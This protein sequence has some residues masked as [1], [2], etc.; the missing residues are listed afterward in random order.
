MKKLSAILILLISVSPVFAQQGKTGYT[1]FSFITPAEISVGKDNNFLVDR[2]PA[3]EKLLILSLPA[4]VLVAAPDIRPLGLDDTVY[5]LKPPTIAFQSDSQR[6]EFSFAYQPEIEI[7]QHNSDQNTWNNNASID[8]SRLL[9]RRWQFYAGDMYRSSKDPSRT[10]QNPLLLLP[11]SRYQENDFRTSVGFG[12]SERTWYTLRFDHTLTTF[13]ENDPLQRRLLD[14]IS[15]SG[16]FVFTRM[17]SRN[18]RLRVSYSIFSLQPWNRQKTAD[19][20]V[21]TQFVAFKKPSHSLTAEYRFTLNPSTVFEFTGGAV[22][23]ST[24]TNYVFGAF[25]D[26]RIGE[27]W[28]GGGYSRTLSLYSP[29][30]PGFAT[31]LNANSFYDIINGHLRGQPTRKTG[32]ELSISVSRSAYGTLIN[33]NKTL[34]GRSRVDYRLNDRTV[35]FATAEVYGQNR[36]DF[37]TTPLTRT[38]LFMGFDYSLS[39]DAQRRTSRLNRDAD[40]VALTEHARMRTK[41]P[42]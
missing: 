33:E 34:L 35:M 29:T 4:T 12:Q 26:R 22:N 28:L 24:G 8:Y 30:N 3:D 7:F 41:P 23:T 25:G 21:D 15:K 40:N 39:S 32:V 11:R 6:R 9:S 1:G 42:Q 2:T 37:V 38:R 27:V 16:T 10:L 20:R 19:D 18:H 31:G 5:Q 14:T 17:L 13:G 36:N